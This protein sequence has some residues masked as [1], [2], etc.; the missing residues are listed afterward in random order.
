MMNVKLDLK[1]VYIFL[2][3][4]FGLAWIAALIIYLTGGLQNSPAVIP[5]TP[6]TLAAVLL[7]SQP[8]DVVASSSPRSYPLADKR[9]LEKCLSAPSN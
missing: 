6:I 7:V 1:R 5:G 9:R 2:A 8:G 3:I 4:T